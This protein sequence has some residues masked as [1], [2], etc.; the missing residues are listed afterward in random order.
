MTY[1]GTWVTAGHHNRTHDPEQPVTNEAV[2]ESCLQ[3]QARRRRLAY[4]HRLD[5]N[6]QCHQELYVSIRSE[7]SVPLYLGTAKCVEESLRFS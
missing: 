1:H 7:D 6:S 4:I 5:N 3:A 2:R